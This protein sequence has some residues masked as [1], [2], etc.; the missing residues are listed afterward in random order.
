M[1]ADGSSL[2]YDPASGQ[3]KYV[4]KTQTSWAGTCRQLLVTLD[5]GSVYKA[6]FKLK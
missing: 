5:D 4:W 6:N 2:S 1:T 3:Y